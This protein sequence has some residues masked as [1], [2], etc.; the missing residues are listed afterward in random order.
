MRRLTIENYFTKAT[1]WKLARLITRE[2]MSRPC[3][4]IRAEK[5]AYDRKTGSSPLRKM[6]EELNHKN[7]QNAFYYSLGALEADEELLIKTLLKTGASF[8]PQSLG[9]TLSCFFPVMEDIVY[10]RH[11]CIE[12]AILSYLMY[13]ARYDCSDEVLNEDYGVLD[14]KPDYGVLLRKCTSG[15]GIVNLHHM[16]TFFIFTIWE[17]AG[18]NREALVPYETLLDWIKDKELDEG[19]I[20]RM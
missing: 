4:S 1:Q 16:I 15:N 12:T 13:L 6:I 14:H 2:M 11:S 8:I 5:I 9:H 3:V 18:F 17:E 20:E 10:L 7:I 19:R